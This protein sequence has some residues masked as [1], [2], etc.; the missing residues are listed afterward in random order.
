MF[1]LYGDTKIYVLCPSGSVT[2]GPEAVHQLVG[3]LIKFGHEAYVVYLP[4]I[5]NPL[6]KAYE[7]YHTKHIDE[8]EDS[9][10]N[11]LITLETWPEKLDLYKNIQKAIWW[12]SI[13]NAQTGATKLMRGVSD[14]FKIN[15]VLLKKYGTKIYHK[16]KGKGKLSF[17]FKADPTVVHLAQSRYAE[18]F[19]HSVG[20]K[21]IFQL[22]DFL[23]RAHFHEIDYP[24]KE[25]IVIFNPKKGKN[26]TEKLMLE[27]PEI[28]WLPIQNMTPAQVSQ[29]M[30]KSKVYID[31]GSHPGKDRMPREAAMKNCCVIVG[32]QGSASFHQDVTI[33]TGFKFSTEEL[34]VVAIVGKIKD[35]F[36]NYDDNFNLF[37][38]YRRIIS[39]NEKQFEEEIKQLFG[40]KNGKI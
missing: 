9:G 24:E 16:I 1:K 3:K 38:Q 4:K 15:N 25:N 21:Y 32:L 22:T 29:T 13:D 11:V 14:S 12:L 36:R 33:P 30:A 34:D 2:G 40:V 28:E 19:L 37:E 5:E 17:D 8:V 27:A 26:I 31:F 20:A 6:P 39:M 23:N 7:H 35:C 10:K 18:Y